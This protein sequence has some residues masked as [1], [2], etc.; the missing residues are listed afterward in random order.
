MCACQ[1]SIQV[2]FFCKYAAALSASTRNKKNNV[3]QYFKHFIDIY[4]IN[5]TDND[6]SLCCVGVYITS[7]YTHDNVNA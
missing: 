1:Y 7:I 3:Y 6:I 2:L 5:L 4:S